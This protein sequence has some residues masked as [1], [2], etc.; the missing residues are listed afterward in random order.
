MRSRRFF[1]LCPHRFNPEWMIAVIVN[2]SSRISRSAEFRPP[3]CTRAL[4]S[5]R[6]PQ[7]IRTDRDRFVAF[8]FTTSHL[9]LETDLRGI[10]TYAAGVPCGLAPSTDALVGRSLSSLASPDERE[11]L[12][13]AVRRVADR[14]G[15]GLL[16]VVLATPTGQDVDVMAGGCRVDDSTE[17][18]HFG[19][20]VSP[21]SAIRRPPGGVH[22]QEGFMA[23]ARTRL[24]VAD[25]TGLEEQMTL[26]SVGDLAAL[27]GHR[28]TTL[29]GPVSHRLCAYLR[30]ISSTGDTVGDLGPG[31]FGAVH[32]R[33]IREAEI[34]AS[35]HRILEDAGLPAQ[36]ETTCI[37]LVS[38]ELR[39]GD[40][41][42]ALD[43]LI[44]GF[45][46]GEL[47]GPEIRTLRDS[48]S[49]LALDTPSRVSRARKLLGDARV[50]VAYLPIVRTDEAT[51]DFLE[52]FL[53][54]SG[55][56]SPA[57]AH[58]D[59][60]GG[61]L[62]RDIDLV[63]VGEVMD[64][65]LSSSRAG[66]RP[67]MALRLSPEALHSPLFCDQLARL[68]EPHGELRRRMVIQVSQTVVLADPGRTGKI[69]ADL[70]L[71]GYRICLTGIG[72]EASVLRSLRDVPADFVKIDGARIS[73]A[74]AEGRDAVFLRGLSTW[75][76]SRGCRI[77]AEGIGTREEARLLGRLGCA[78]TQGPLFGP[79]GSDPAAFGARDG[80]WGGTWDGTMAHQRRVT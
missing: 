30:S 15:M 47:P 9:L 68:T 24:E 16:R 62:M 66:W 78:Y 2:P 51:V 23:A 6:M 67:D 64:A 61:F 80:N 36:V 5:H 31:R 38:G 44:G 79:P 29:L 39:E 53:M 11:F 32:P 77:I 18:L 71:S 72:A 7:T 28:D 1:E 10:I 17:T 70:R 27:A 46:G 20:I 3:S 45:S 12:D 34:A 26:V 75:S 65:L 57:F 40:A 50:A 33:E 76:S 21:S 14:R 60:A 37:T 69:L 43:H 8:A 42:R 48:A 74:A 25:R 58:H 73:R 41:A 49:A 52:A 19:L 55:P 56:L 59:P 4:M 22:D 35:F 54:P 63:L 13:Y